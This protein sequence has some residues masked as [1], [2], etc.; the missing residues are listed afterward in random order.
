MA[1]DTDAECE[2]QKKDRQ[3]HPSDPDE[4]VRDDIIDQHVPMPEIFGDLHPY[5]SVVY[6][7]G[8]ARAA[9]LRVAMPNFEK[10]GPRRAGVALENRRMIIERREERESGIVD[11]R[12]GI[13]AV[14]LGIDALK[15]RRKLKRPSAIGIPRQIARNDGGMLLQRSVMQFVRRGIQ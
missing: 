15:S 5:V 10:G 1:E 9:E 2:Q 12:I 11:D 8:N 13:A 6:F 3:G 7:L 4:E 14:C